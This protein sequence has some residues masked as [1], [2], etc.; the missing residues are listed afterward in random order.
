[1]QGWRGRWNRTSCF[2]ESPIGIPRAMQDKLT[3]MIPGPT[4][5]PE[6]VLK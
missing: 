4:P 1:M 3:L 6:T 5:V 2:L